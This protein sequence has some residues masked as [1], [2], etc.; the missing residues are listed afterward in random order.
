MKKK[1]YSPEF[2]REAVR[3]LMTEDRPVTELAREIQHDQAARIAGRHEPGT[4][5]T[6][7][8]GRK[9]DSTTEIPNKM[10]GP[11]VGL[12]SAVKKVTRE[13][14]RALQHN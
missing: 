6:A 12:A 9:N 7:M 1:T 14:V 13:A 3:L 10:S 11:K 4:V 2:K 8:D 5:S